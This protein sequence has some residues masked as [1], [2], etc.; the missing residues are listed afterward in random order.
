[1]PRQSH[2]TVSIGLACESVT[3]SIAPRAASPIRHSPIATL[4]TH[5]TI[6]SNPT[7]Q[8]QPYSAAQSETPPVAGELIP[9]RRRS[10]IKIEASTKET[11][12][13]CSSH[14]AM[15]SQGSEAPSASRPRRGGRT[16]NTSIL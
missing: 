13:L 14:F 11:P 15:E 8:R 10:R 16:K 12:P 7:Q 4:P 5:S 3:V 6:G 1:S 2:V 9:R